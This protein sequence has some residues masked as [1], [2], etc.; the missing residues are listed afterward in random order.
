M[1]KI[2]N[3]LADNYFW[4]VLIIFIAIFFNTC[5]QTKTN[6]RLVRQNQQLIQQLDSIKRDFV[7]KDEL[8]LYIKI[9]GYEVSENILNDFNDYARSKATPTERSRYYQTRREE[10]ERQLLLLRKK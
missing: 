3:F 4:I 2:K 6:K 5:S 10:L 1:E 8:Q 7:K 9:G